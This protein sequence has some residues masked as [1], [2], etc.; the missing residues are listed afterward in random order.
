MQKTKNNPTRQQQWQ[1]YC[2][3]FGSSSR[4]SS[5]SSSSSKKIQIHSRVLEAIQQSPFL[6]GMHYAFQTDSKLYLILDYVS[7]GELFTHLYTAEHFSVP[8]VRI[9]IA[10]VVLALEHLH[11]LE[12]IRAGAT[13]HDLAADCGL[14][15]YSPMNCSLAPRLLQLSNNKFSSR[16]FTSHTKSIRFYRRH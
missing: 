4:S 11:K 9:Y 5:S 1:Y 13:G 7:G 8:T 6:V 12:I 15:A 2:I 16:H 3:V 10:E 14:W